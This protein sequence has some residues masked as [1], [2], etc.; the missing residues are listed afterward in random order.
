MADKLKA[1][2]RENSELKAAKLMSMLN[3]S[4]QLQKP[5]PHLDKQIEALKVQLSE[6]TNDFLR[7]KEENDLLREQMVSAQ[8]PVHPVES[9]V[10]ELDK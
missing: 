2:E 4:A 5:S 10:E 9:P 6:K 3:G 1:L 8:S 7:L